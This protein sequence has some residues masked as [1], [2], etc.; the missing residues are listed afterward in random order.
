MI[1][2]NI[3]RNAWPGAIVQFPSSARYFMRVAHHDEDKNGVIDIAT[4]EYIPFSELNER[5]L[6]ME[7]RIVAMNL[8][9][10]VTDKEN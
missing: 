10:F 6:G 5:R 4:G 3:R 2:T 9:D 1:T 7:A 8:E